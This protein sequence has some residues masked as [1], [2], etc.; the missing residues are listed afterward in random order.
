MHR[1]RT[2][3]L[4]AL[5]LLHA[6]ALHA[7]KPLNLDLERPGFAYPGT[8]WGWYT[9]DQDDPS[10]GHP[11]QMDSVVRHGGRWSLRV[12]RDSAAGPWFGESWFA[13]DALAGRRV[14]LS[15]WVRTQNVQGGSAALRVDAMDGNYQTLS[16]DSMPGRALRGTAGW[17]QLVVETTL[18][19]NVRAL[20]V[21]GQVS[22]TG[23]VWFDDLV[24]EIDGRAV[25]TE[26]GP[27]PP[28][29][30]QRAWLR[31]A[32]VPF[33]SVEPGGDDAD[34]AAFRSLVGDARVVSLGEG[35]HGTRE[36]FTLKHRM[37]ESLVRR[38]GFGVV[39]L[40]ANQLQAER[41]NRYV[42]TG[43]GSAREALSGVFKVLQTDE[44]LAMVEWA[45]AWNASGRGR[46]EVVGYDM[47][48]PRLPMDSVLAFLRTADPAFAPEAE[49]A[50]AAM[51]TAWLPGPYPVR[52]DSVVRAW[53]ASADVVRRHVREHA[54]AYLARGADRARV[55]WAVQ[56]AEV[57]FQSAS[58]GDL[59]PQSVRDSAMAANIAW[60]LAQRPAGTR[61]VV[62]A[63]NSHV[64]RGPG[65]MGTYLDQMLP[66]Q[67]RV[68]GFTTAEGAYTAAGNW[69]RDAA[70][71]TMGEFPL[72]PVPPPPGSLAAEL[73]AL[74][75][76]RLLLDLRGAAAGEG[77]WLA[78]PRP[79]LGI[80]GRVVDYG[81]YTIPIARLYDAVVYLRTT[82]ASRPM[83]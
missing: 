76:A 72:A 17:T 58:L 46:V 3:A 19:E 28:T 61:A 77:A 47:Q 41:I 49:R 55:A 75:A 42:L 20:G 9:A 26:P 44:V 25:T 22:G 63:H 32:A 2:L 62:W 10:L 1:S 73:Y 60:T 39:M 18:G 54:P 70:S 68:V 37:I 31:S 66:G 11:A 51:H 64:M 81:Y 15:G 13:G 59:T 21:G 34:L 29:A 83:R 45:R 5:A 23:T 36:F 79:F 12:A 43:Q 74:G 6:G 69:A 78:E 14:R 35:T 33:A 82:T 48:D 52:P 50:Y 4:A 24:L 67:V 71:R 80:G 57:A 30:A 40:E 27:A 16:V 56:N 38:M 8:P 65:W 53:S 7:Q